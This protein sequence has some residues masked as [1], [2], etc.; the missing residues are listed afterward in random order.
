MKEAAGAPGVDRE[1]ATRRAGHWGVQSDVGEINSCNHGG[2]VA[3]KVPSDGF[4]HLSRA[5]GIWPAP[6][7]GWPVGSFYPL[8]NLLHCDS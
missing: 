5:V 6:R 3:E 1:S 8:D 2:F 4:S 7:Y